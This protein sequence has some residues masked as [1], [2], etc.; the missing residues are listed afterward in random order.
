MKK[1]IQL[2]PEIPGVCNFTTEILAQKNTLVSYGNP[3]G[4]FLFQYLPEK[5]LKQKELEK[6]CC[7]NFFSDKYRKENVSSG[8]P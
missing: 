5:K 8:V 6:N 4:T 1:K 7:F 2:I 3:I